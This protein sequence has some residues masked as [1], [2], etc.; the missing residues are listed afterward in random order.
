M[1][2]RID[3]AAQHLCAKSD[4]KLSNLQLQKIIYMADMNFV[5]KY[6]E[7]LVN[8][9]FEAW[10]YGPVLPSLYHKCK[11]FGA[12]SV[13]PVFWGADD[14]SDTREGEMLD[15]A[16]ERLKSLSPGQLVETTHSD[17]GAWVRRYAPG[18]KQIKILS[19][20]MIDEYDRRSDHASR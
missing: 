3:D 20:D 16:W 10:D 12:K 4:W 6:G 2:V 11:A 8:E 19:Q 1:T 5:G 13:P 7:R 9:D 15:L 14:I 17:L 18:A